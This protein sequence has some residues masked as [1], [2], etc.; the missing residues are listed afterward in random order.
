MHWTR[1]DSSSRRRRARDGLTV[2]QV[3]SGT[4]TKLVHAL[5]TAKKVNGSVMFNTTVRLIFDLHATHGIGM[6]VFGQA[7]LLMASGARGSGTRHPISE[8]MLLMRMVASLTSRLVMRMLVRFMFHV[9]SGKKWNCHTVEQLVNS[10]R[11][12][13]GL[14]VFL[15]M[16]DRI[17]WDFDGQVSIGYDRLT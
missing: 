2:T 5:G 11:V 17:S 15:C 1:V 10:A 16:I 7:G 9:G 12:A 3:V 13:V 4:S 14:I 6:S 8:W